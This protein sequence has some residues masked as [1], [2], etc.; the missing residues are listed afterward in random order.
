MLI[1]QN[2]AAEV[3]LKKRPQKGIWGG[4]IMPLNLMVPCKYTLNVAIKYGV[5]LIKANG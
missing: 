5:V 3:Y 1:Y 2:T 4:P